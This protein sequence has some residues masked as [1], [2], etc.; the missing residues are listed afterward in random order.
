MTAD[1]PRPAGRVL[2]TG[3]AGFI[4][5]K[6]VELLRRSGAEVIGADDLN[7]YYSPS[8]KRARLDWLERLDAPGP[9][10]FHHVDLADRRAAERLFDS[11]GPVA[12]VI[13]LAAQAGVRHSLSHPHAYAAA[14]LDGFLN[15]LEGCRRLASVSAGDC[16][17]PDR[18]PPHLVYASSSSVYGANEAATLKTSDPA[19]HPLS[20]YAATKRANELMAHSYAH[21]YGLPC[22]GLRF[23]SVYGPW[24]RPDMAAWIF[25]ER[26]LNNEPIEVFGEGKMSRSFTYIDEVAEAVVRVAALPPTAPPPGA[27]PDRPDVGVGPVRILNVGGDESVELMRLVAAVEAACGRTAEKRFLPMQPG[28]V[29]AT[30][31]DTAPLEALVGLTPRTTV[32]DGIARFVAWYQEFHGL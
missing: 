29:P 7:P 9:F 17:D 11:A 2:V 25:T 32:E 30:A 31:A 22:T 12:C 26:I 3:A 16:G 27:L 6:V 1:P 23:F 4:G 21:L 19:D 14:N 20:L 10:T 13:H 8:L 15:V 28:D 24:G 18:P 5:S